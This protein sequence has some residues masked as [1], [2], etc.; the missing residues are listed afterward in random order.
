MSCIMHRMMAVA[1]SHD[2]WPRTKH[3]L[4]MT[5]AIVVWQCACVVYWHN[6]F[7]TN[8]IYALNPRAVDNVTATSYC[9]L[10]GVAPQW[11]A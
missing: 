2:L 5:C 8:A 7:D 10:L 3:A 11:T 9:W 6:V 4:Q 1:V